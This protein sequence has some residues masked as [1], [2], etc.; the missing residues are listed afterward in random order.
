MGAPGA[1]GRRD[2]GARGASEAGSGE[3]PEDGGEGEDEEVRVLRGGARAAPERDDE[4]ERELAAL[5][6]EHQ[7]RAAPAAPAAAVRFWMVACLAPRLS[8]FSGSSLSLRHAF[9]SNLKPTRPSMRRTHA[10]VPR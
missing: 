4:F 1:R 3:E 7:G 9:V 5:V 6:L 2:A 10:G 8:P